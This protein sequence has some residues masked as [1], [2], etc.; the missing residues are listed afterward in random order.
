MGHDSVRQ[1]NAREL[2]RRTARRR[3]YDRVLIVSE[4]KKTE[5]NYFNEIRAALRL[6]TANVIALASQ[7]G[8]APTQV[9]EYAQHV[10]LNGDPR[11]Q[12]SKRAFERVY[13]VFDRDDHASY[14]E[15]LANIEAWKQ[16]K[17]K[18]DEKAPIHIE[19]VPSIPCF[20]LWLLLHFED[21]QSP[22]P[23]Q[24]VYARLKKYLGGYDKGASDTFARTKEHL[25]RA[26]ERAQSLARQGGPHA[27]GPFTALSGI[28][29]TL[30]SLQR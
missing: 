18:N 4:G 9:V 16:R 29:A 27:D 24:E 14:F 3:P 17:P 7:F 28:V 15:A 1:R 6:S 2:A 30:F 21:V 20:E 8:T 25:A 19:A 22:L 10:F 26:H 5:P 23:R 13:A 12:I 11:R